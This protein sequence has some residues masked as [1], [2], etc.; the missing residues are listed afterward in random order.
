M[1]LEQTVGNGFC[2][3]FAGWDFFDLKKFDGLNRDMTK[4]EPALVEG[5]KMSLLYKICQPE[6]QLSA[7]DFSKSAKLAALTEVPASCGNP[8]MTSDAFLMQD[9]ECKYSFRDAS[10]NGIQDEVLS[11]GSITYKGFTLDLKSSESCGDSKFQVTFT[12]Q[13]ADTA[14]SFAVSAENDCS[15]VIDYSGPEACKLY[16]FEAGKHLSKLLPF[17]G[18]FAILLG[19]AMAFYG[20]KFLF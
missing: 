13:C 18:G 16:T 3:V 7:Q 11:D 8:P 17:V 9:G 5:E 20:A 10:F 2:Q 4:S 14:G 19:I 12:A 15:M 6:W 1:N